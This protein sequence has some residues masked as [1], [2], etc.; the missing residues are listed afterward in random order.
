[1]KVSARES[2]LALVTVSVALFGITG[3]LARSKVDELKLIRQQQQLARASIEKRIRLEEMRPEYEQRMNELKGMM[4]PFPP[5]KRMQVFWS[6]HME[7][8]ASK[9]GM[10]IVRYEVG[11]EK[12]EGPIYELPIECL[13]WEGSLDALVHFL[14][15]LQ[16]EGAML[17]IRYLR[18]KPKDKVMR[19][20]RFS[21]Y[22][23]YM[24]ESS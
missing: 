24:R 12:Q 2:L 15:D 1:M 10:K 22:C 23:A 13:D 11:S 7:S 5:D 20:G 9:N 17:D 8:L 21:L 18:V 4:K 19:T 3:V 14:F 6:S 16:S